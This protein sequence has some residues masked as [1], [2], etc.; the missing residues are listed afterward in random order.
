MMQMTEGRDERANTLS[1]SGEND[2]EGSAPETTIFVYGYGPMKNPFYEQARA[3]KTTPRG[4]VL[5]LSSPV[6]R[7]QKLLLMNGAGSEPVEAEVVRG[8]TLDSQMFEAVI[9]FTAPQPDFWAPFR[10]SAKTNAG[11]EKRRSPRL[12]LPRGMTISWNSP[13]RR[14]VSRVSSLSTS[15][16]FIDADDP[17]PEGQMI[18]VHFEL[19][20][21]PVLGK[22][23]VRRSI[24]GKG[25]GVEF[26]ELPEVQRAAL[27]DLMLRLLGR[28]RNRK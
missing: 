14:D 12:S 3:L 16:L 22:A 7:G 8:R 5:M 24:R 10:K 28:R 23:V 9:L 13:Y 20:S 18:Q 4:A 2:F 27:A 26:T 6:S 1:G 21:G 11:P 17:A 15:G 19:P 25:M